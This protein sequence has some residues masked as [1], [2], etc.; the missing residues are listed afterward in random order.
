MNGAMPTALAYGLIIGAALIGMLWQSFDSYVPLYWYAAL[1]IVS[2]LRALIVPGIVGKNSKPLI[3][4]DT[5]ESRIFWTMVGVVFSG[6]TWGS[7]AFLLFSDDPIMQIFLAFILGGLSAGA[8]TTLYANRLA[9]FGFLCLTLVPLC[10]RFLVMPESLDQ[11]MG[12]MMFLFCSG[13]MLSVARA[14]RQFVQSVFDAYQA[15]TIPA[16][17]EDWRRMKGRADEGERI[18]Q[19]YIRMMSQTHDAVIGFDLDLKINFWSDAAETILGYRANTVLG[20]SILDHV[21]DTDIKG[22]KAEIPERMRMEDYLEKEI[23]FARESNEP[24]FLKMSMIL[25]RNDDGEPEAVIAYLA[26]IDELKKT[27]LALIS[28][29]KKYKSVVNSLPLGMIIFESSKSS[30]LI[31]RDYNPAADRILGIDCSIYSERPVEQCFP[32]LAIS[33]I[34]ERLH[35]VVR[36][37]N[38]WSSEQIRYCDDEI[39]GGFMVHAFKIDENRAALCFVDITARLRAERA[40]RENEA[41]LDFLVT[42]S[43]VVIYSCKITETAFVPTFVSRNIS[44]I[45]GYSPDECLGNPGWWPEHLHPDDKAAAF[46]SSGRIFSENAIMHEYRFRMRD[47]SY[48]WIRDEVRVIRDENGVATEIIGYW[49][50]ISEQKRAE[51]FKDEFIATVSHELRTPLTSIRGAL[52]LLEGGVAFAS[53]EDFSRMISIA[54]SNSERLLLLINDILDIQ[55]LDSGVSQFV[56]TTFELGS[57]LEGVV[58]DNVPFAGQFGVEIRVDL[59]QRE[60]IITS[61]ASRLAQVVTNLLSNAVKHSPRGSEVTVSAGTGGGHL[62][63]DVIDQGAGVPEEFLSRLFDPFSQADSS[64]TRLRGGTGLGLSIA[65]SIVERLGGRIGYKPNPDGGSIFWLEVPVD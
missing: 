22:L 40:L 46:A 38:P 30:E 62:N 52:G 35:E 37:G 64:N 42:G 39:G 41:Q 9:G 17:R 25:V 31:P 33:D 5:L 54:S 4:L 3:G 61:D 49:A 15:A 19:N 10:I 51:K 55:K 16:I 13:M 11:V 48:R 44:E 63:I 56:S 28:S 7:T 29:E 14:N 45:L 1:V 20:K 2:L 8:T 43:P 47:D 21:I 23:R 57:W 12:I 50:D 65:R 32:E 26:D 59:K 60:Q 24:I 36:T 58:H 34:S 27:E 6:L 18:I 53:Q